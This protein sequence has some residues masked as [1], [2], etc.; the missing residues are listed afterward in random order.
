MAD[1]A[2]LVP[3]YHGPAYVDLLITQCFYFGLL[4]VT[5]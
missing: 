1:V 3:V 4:I 5:V 2:V